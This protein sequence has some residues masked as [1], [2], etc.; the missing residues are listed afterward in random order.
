MTLSIPD[1][2]V[3]RHSKKNVKQ[4]KAF[5]DQI[6]VDTRLYTYWIEWF[7]TLPLWLDLDGIRVVHACWNGDEIAR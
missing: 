5:T 2:F 1:E 4:H 6:P 7:R 3:R